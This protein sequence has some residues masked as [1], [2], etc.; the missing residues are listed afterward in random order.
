MQKNR[1]RHDRAKVA[2]NANFR[3][4]YD[5]TDDFRLK[6]NPIPSRKAEYLATQMWSKFVSMDTAPP[7]V[8][9]QRAINKW[10]AT[11]MNNSASNDRL[12]CV[13]PGFNILPRVP[14]ESFMSTVREL[15]ARVIGETVPSS[16]VCDVTFGLFSS[17]ATTSRPRTQS[18]P[19]LKY[20]GEAHVTPRCLQW[21]KSALAASPLWSQIQSPD[22]YRVMEGNVLFTVPKNT[23]IDRC[24][25][26]EPDL[27]MYF[28]KGVGDF[29]RRRLC[30]FGIDLNNQSRNQALARRGSTDGSLATV[31]LSSASDSI[32][33]ELVAQ[34]LPAMWLTYLDD[35]R[36]PVTIIDGERHVNHMYSSMG[37][38]FTFE[39][40]SLLFWA[41]AKATAIHTGT[42]GTIS[43]YGDDII[44]P[45]EMC[46]CFLYVLSFL[47]FTPNWEKTFYEGDFRESCGGHFSGGVCVT[48]FYIRKP[49]THLADVITLANQVRKWCGVD[50]TSDILDC[51]VEEVWTWL[52]TF[53]PKCFWGGTDLN[54]SSRLVSLETPDFPKRLISISKRRE[55]GGGGY[56]WW[57]DTFWKRNVP[58]NGLWID[59]C[60]EEPVD[61]RL[62]FSS[63]AVPSGRYRSRKVGWFYGVTERVFLAEMQS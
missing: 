23:E 35:I 20:T 10:L 12:L 34:C 3:L 39:L 2:P 22:N 11:E 56:M 13:D 16:A 44:V 30:Q 60:S 4:P 40:E 57:L 36:C 18:H 48:P 26:K 42:R 49:I 7:L 51:D 8:R 55:S 9:R 29:I 25:C 37:N 33:Y 38:G 6:W 5:L 47:G 62:E 58:P 53:V 46:Q 19:A 59:S 50:H 15:I 24:A 27:N 17:G 21:A 61:E 63:Y 52:S 41:I 43:V 14:Y 54:D 32:C 45:S 1:N 31:D 28:Q